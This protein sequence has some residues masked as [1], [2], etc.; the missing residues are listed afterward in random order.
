MKTIIF[1]LKLEAL[2]FLYR[3]NM[4]LLS[5]IDEKYEFTLERLV[6]EIS[7]ATASK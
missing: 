3:I 7:L 4:F 5:I 6:Y 2:V 1:N